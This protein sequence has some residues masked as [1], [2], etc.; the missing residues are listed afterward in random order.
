VWE[1]VF[2]G[3]ISK[4]S[5]HEILVDSLG[6]QQVAAKFVPCLRHFEQKQKCLK[7][8]QEL[9]DRANNDKNFL[10]NIITGD[11]TWI[12]SCDVKSKAQSSQWVSEVSPNAKG[13]ASSVKYEGDVKFLYMIFLL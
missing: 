10:E 6:M 1:V 8:S 7:L 2:E 4:S 12:Y 13:T 11:E 9:F 5:C 3:G